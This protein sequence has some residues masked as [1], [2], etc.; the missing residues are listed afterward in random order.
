MELLFKNY[1]KTASLMLYVV[2]RAIVNNRMLHFL[3][4]CNCIAP[5]C[6]NQ[7]GH[8]I[9]ELECNCICTEFKSQ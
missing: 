3:R 9:T 7:N 5:I 8:F 1:V 4:L 2:C 6:S